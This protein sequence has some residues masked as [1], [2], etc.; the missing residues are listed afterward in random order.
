MNFKETD[1]GFEWG[2]VKIE[3]HIE[4]EGAVII[5]IETALGI[6]NLY[7]TPK[8]KIKLV[9]PH[10]QEVTVISS[11]RKTSCNPAQDD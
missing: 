11:M 7:V 5:G 4:N 8:G 6:F 2:P 1:Y 3:R 10:G 9:V